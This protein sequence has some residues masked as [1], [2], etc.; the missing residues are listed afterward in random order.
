MST[1][2]STNRAVVYKLVRQALDTPVDNV[3]KGSR[4]PVDKYF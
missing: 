2:M 1:Q 4:S 3:D